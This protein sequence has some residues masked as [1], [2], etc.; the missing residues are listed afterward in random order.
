MNTH[1][2]IQARFAQSWLSTPLNAA[3]LAGALLAGFSIAPAGAVS[4]RTTDAA[5]TSS[6]TGSTNWNP[7]GVATAGNAYFTGAFTIRTTNYAVNGGSIAVT[8]AGDSLSID[9]GGRMIGKMGNN[10]TV[11]NA[12][13][14]TYTANYI[15]N[16]GIMDQASGTGGN[17]VLKIAGTVTVNAASFLGAIGATSDNNANFCT[18]E[19]IAPISGSADLQVSGQNVNGGADT[20]VLKLSAANP[21]GGTITVPVSRT[22][23]AA[24]ASAVN[25][26]LQ[27]NNLNALSNATLNLTTT[28][29]NPVS[30]A[31]AA[32]TGPFNVGALSGSSSQTLSDTVGGAV[33][34]SVGGKNT[35][36]TYSGALMDAGALV[37]VGSGTLTLTGTNSYF[38]STTVNGGSLRLGNGGVSGALSSS[39]TIT[40]NGNLTINRNNAVVQGTDFSSS[41]ITGTGS[42]TQ[43]GAGVTTLNAANSYSGATTVNAGKL[44]IS[45]AQTGTGPIT[46]TN[47]AKLGITVSGASQLPPSTLTL[48]TSAATTLEFDGLNSTTVAPINAGTLTTGGTVTVNINTGTF[49]AG[50]SYPLIHWTTSGPADASSFTL[51]TSPGLTATFSVSSSTLFLN[52]TAVSDIWSGTVNGNWD[53]AT[54]NWTG[55]ATIFANGQSVLFDDTA[56]G[57][58]SVTVNTPVLPGSMVFNNS[59]LIYNI[60]S[61]AANNIGGSGGLT[62]NNAGS[63]TLSGG[64]NT[65]AGATTIGG[66]T[67]SV[68]ALANGGSPS[69]LGAATAA[70][71]NLT[72]NGGTLQYTGTTAGTDRGATLGSGGGTVEITTGGENLTD[73]GVIVGSGSLT[74]T[75]NG[76]LTLSGANTFSGGVTLSAGQLNINNGGSS[77]A[78]SAIG[79]GILTIAA[80]TTIDNTSGSDVTLLPNNAQVWSGSFTY[81]GSVPNNL[82]LG[83]GAVTL[84]TT[85]T[86]TVNAGTMSV[87]GVISGTFGVTKAGAGALLLSG[88]NTYGNNGASDTAVNGGT[89]IIGN[90][91]SLGSS[92]LNVA[93]G[94][95]IQSADSTAHTLT[96][97]LNFGSG[98][99]GNNIFAGTGNLKFTG[100]ANNGTAKTM[101][102]NNPQTEFS[103]VLSGAMAR[104]VAGTGLLIFS[105]ANTYSA[106]TTINPGATLQLG[107]GGTNGS[108]STSGPIDDE[109]TLIF[110]HSNALVQGVH[111]SSAPITGAGAVVQAGSGTTTLN[112]ANTYSGLTA[113]NN[114]E[115]F[116][117]PAYQGGGN[118]VVADGAKFGV[119]ASS[120]SN[121]ATI[122]ALTLGSGGATTLDFSYGFV[123]NPTNAALTAGA[124]TINGTS[125]IRIGGTLAVGTFPVLK[126]TS[127]SGAFSSTVV[128]PRGVTATLSNDIPNQTLY[129]I[130]SSVGGGIVWTGTNSVSPNLWDLNTTVNWLI[131]GL[132]TVYLENVPPGDA[133][134]FNDLGSGTVLLSNTVSPASVTI[135]NTTV[136]YSFDGTGQIT[137]SGGLTKTSSGAVT[138]NLPGTYAGNTVISNGTFSIGANQSF[139][140]L[141]GNGTV[142]SSTGAPVLTINSGLDSTFAGNIEGALNLTKIGNSTLTLTASNSFS[143]N[144]F[145]KSGTL[146]LSSGGIFGSTAFSSIGQN[147][148]DNGTLTLNGNASFTNNADFNVGDVGSSVGTLNVSNNASLTVNAFFVGSANATGSTASGT[149]NQAGGTVNQ[150]NTGTG[151]FDLGGRTSASGVGV[152]NLSGGTLTAAAGIRVGNSG[153]GTMNQSGGTAIAVGGVDVA[154]NVGAFGTYNLSGGTLR[155]IRVTSSTGANATFNFDGGVLQAMSPALPFMSALTSAY[156]LAG[157]AIIDSAANNIV[158][159]QTLLDGGTGGGLTKLG[160]GSLA[161]T[162]LGTSYTGPTRVAAGTLSLSFGSVA[163]LNNLTVSNAALTVS[164][165]D[166]A[167]SVPAANLT[168]TGNTALSFDYDFVSAPTVA[169][170]NASGNLTVSGTSVVNVSGY[171]LTVGQFTLVDYTGTPLANLNN[172]QLGALPFGVSASL[173]NN[174][175]NTS[176]DLV[177]TAVAIASWIPL[178][179]TDAVGTSGFNSAGTWQDG[180][181]P[182]AANGYFTRTFSLRSPAD[183]SAY[184]FGGAALAIDSGGRFIMKGTNGQAM[185]VPNLIINGGLVD[186]A[187]ALDNFTETLGGAITL[188]PGSVNYLG[189]L[190]SA[191]VSETLFVNAPISGSGNLQIGGT[192]VNNGQDVGTVVLAGTNTYTGT[193]TV[194]TGTL[195]VN[196]SIGSAAATVNN[197]ATLGGNGTIA[198]PVTIQVG[199]NLAPGTSSRGALTA[200]LGTLTVGGTVTVAGSVLMKIDRAAS[201]NSDRLIAPAVVVNA[202]A[203]LA[204]NNIGSTNLVVGDTFTLFS[205]PVSGSFSITSLPPLPS[206]SLY[207]TNKLSVNGT[208]AVASAVTVNT[209]P[210]NITATVSGNT[211]TLSWPAD[212]LGWRLQVQ[213]NTPSSGLGTNWV[214][215]PG[216]DAVISTNIIINPANGSVFF[217]MVYP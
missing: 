119:T 95:T 177:V 175:A 87:G 57:T 40:D 181:P 108:L 146:T 115:L 98:A 91:F 206:S 64:A 34:L 63:L 80:N 117:T 15:L 205:T 137:S 194:D 52:V 212:H 196:G 74:K 138:M 54:A 172:F 42:L 111:F 116:F 97:N 28:A 25:R 45:S 59:S 83:T 195:L 90:D 94:V 65:Y 32:N 56:A 158:I 88:A 118:V 47:G 209:T 160:T 120:V 100:S 203:T 99:G 68:G 103:G 53:T 84:T 93:D 109:G 101:T 35:N 173:S 86:V 184:I 147:G 149:V 58:T 215:I 26:M 210:T 10:G 12:S 185:T 189:A 128:G 66:G 159:S 8:F 174:T 161:M 110:N 67:L 139:A 24:I 114:G 51:G 113:V 183:A 131:G 38:G 150:L 214:T 19:I 112:A 123:G 153:T 198:G 104:T 50:N 72:L 201:T 143:G 33:T 134:T 76:T 85:P 102:V 75:G 105:G 106:G 155:T 211:L 48:G 6:F 167:P 73:S 197:S 180:N 36:T 133:V 41:A 49:V 4:L 14:G 193:T 1:N 92:R 192:A 191:T 213:T 163:N 18:L 164:L 96:N 11:G 178:T 199:G 69:D 152:Y 9:T 148:T 55:N 188:N 81:A 70:S 27:L 162:G 20:G 186:Y 124:V 30:F 204:V 78:N 21:Y 142:T 23:N 43:A 89:L 217:R 130:V 144:V 176:I 125:A 7:T 60:A 187:N 61:S 200:S 44:V 39:G 46:V 122:G 136:N 29:V 169:A 71:A 77:S 121:S 107:N 22:A 16:G 141:T 208:I 126:Y 168:L 62:K 207:W 166:G 79:T 170:I 3:F 2:S 165:N 5:G 135:N 157:G 156:I 31:S 17:D 216:S 129:A 202:G 132:A 140:N 179:A 171:G 145:V 37:K 13:T 154:R 127:L 182:S 82:N 190:G 151:L